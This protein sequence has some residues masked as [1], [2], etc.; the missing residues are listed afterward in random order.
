MNKVQT[1]QARKPKYYL[2]IMCVWAII[3]SIQSLG[4]LA[5]Q[6][7]ISAKEKEIYRFKQ[8]AEN[9]VQ[10]V[11]WKTQEQLWVD[12]VL[13]EC[14]RQMTRVLFLHT[15][16][17]WEGVVSHLRSQSASSA[18]RFFHFKWAIINFSLW[19]RFESRQQRNPSVVHLVLLI[20]CYLCY[21]FGSV[22]ILYI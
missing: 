21:V 16:S 5:S 6:G 13:S 22:L 7:C 15:K 8:S 20:R 14:C 11:I 9:A 3:C 17:V 1:V 2:H 4:L 10:Q 19:C 12:S 18:W